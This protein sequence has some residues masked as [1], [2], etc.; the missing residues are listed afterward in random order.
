MLAAAM[1]VATAGYVPAAM[2][3]PQR[4]VAA[5]R[6]SAVTMGAAHIVAKKKVIVDE[7]KETLENTMLM[8]CVRS[9]GIPVNEL[10]AVRQKLPE[11]ATM[12]CVKNTLV[13]RAI[14][15]DERFPVSE[16]LL[17]YSNY[18]FF[19]PEADVRATV[20]TWDKFIDETKL[21]RHAPARHAHA[22][23]HSAPE[24][25]QGGLVLGWSRKAGEQRQYTPGRPPDGWVAAGGSVRRRAPLAVARGAIAAGRTP[26]LC[27]PRLLACIAASALR[28][29][30]RSPVAAHRRTTRSLAA[31]S[32]VRCSTPRAS[33]RSPSC[34]RSRS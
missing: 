10:N 3:S 29:T 27:D 26:T 30:L 19:V 12:R 16:D 2:R 34:R 11:G 31:C 5:D 28:P 8:F 33:R 6:S 24:R 13:K 7:V 23:W 18:W 22:L 9:E 1:I 14:E 4:A 20:E 32:R 15:G 17:Q 25:P 21:V